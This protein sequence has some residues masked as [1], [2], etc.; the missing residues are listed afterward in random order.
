MLRGSNL[1]WSRWNEESTKVPSM[2]YLLYLI[3][4][5]SF[6]VSFII[7]VSVD[8]TKDNVGM[9]KN[10][11][12]C[13]SEN[14]IKILLNRNIQ[15]QRQNEH[16]LCPVK[17]LTP[18]RCA[19]KMSN[20]NKFLLHNV[21]GVGFYWTQCSTQ[22]GIISGTVVP[23]CQTHLHCFWAQKIFRIKNGWCCIDA[24]KFA[25]LTTCVYLVISV[26]EWHN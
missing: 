17:K 9:D 16:T 23:N 4:A 21:Y 5:L 10:W 13:K 12:K 20:L 25:D 22:F 1:W 26:L 24:I 18:R 2:L 3:L 8:S 11:E 7:I 15:A 14:K 6:L 19:V